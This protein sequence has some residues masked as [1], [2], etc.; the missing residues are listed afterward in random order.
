[1]YDLVYHSC[2][3]MDFSIHKYTELNYLHMNYVKL[4]NQMPMTDLEDIENLVE[5]KYPVFN[6]YC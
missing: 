4:M 2:I 1:M 3:K 5:L 6:I